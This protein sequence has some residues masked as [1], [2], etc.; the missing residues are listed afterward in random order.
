MKGKVLLKGEVAFGVVVHLQC[1]NRVLMVE[2]ASALA[3]LLY[4]KIL[5]GSYHHFVMCTVY[6]RS[7][8]DVPASEYPLSSTKKSTIFDR[9]LAFRRQVLN[10][11][12]TRM[13]LKPIATKTRYCSS[14][15]SK[16]NQFSIS[17]R[18][19]TKGNGQSFSTH[20]AVSV[21]P[22]PGPHSWLSSHCPSLI[23]GTTSAA[24][25]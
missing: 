18:R 2:L 17:D 4:D 8:N 15:A 14:P 22:M 16:E 13:K 10:I 20:W 1:L 24:S 11:N 9:P 12:P 23:G 5:P 7:S 25:S 21:A 3:S 6:S 19:S